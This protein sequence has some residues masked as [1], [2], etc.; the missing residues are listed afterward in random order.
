MILA[1]ESPAVVESFSFIVVQLNGLVA[2]ASK[3]IVPVCI[4]VRMYGSVTML[5]LLRSQIL[6]LPSLVHCSLDSSAMICRTLEAQTE[7][8][9]G[10]CS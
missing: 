4:I 2:L 9:S 10:P 3:K 1:T 8:V 5:Y 6:D 7:Q